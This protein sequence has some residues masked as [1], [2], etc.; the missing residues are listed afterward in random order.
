MGAGFLQSFFFFFLLPGQL[1]LP[2]FKC[3]VR[4]GHGLPLPASVGLG[5]SL[6]H[7]GTTWAFLF[8]CSFSGVAPG[9]VT[10]GLR[11]APALAS[12]LGLPTLKAARL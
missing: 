9:E 4:F 5:G 1:S 11:N 7:F 3:V 6:S 12:L 10:Q 2:F 8:N